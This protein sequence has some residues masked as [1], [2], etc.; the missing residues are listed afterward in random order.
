MPHKFN[1]PRRHRI[2]RAKYRVTNWPEYDRGLVER[3]DVR[4]WIADDAL[5]AWVPPRRCRRGRQARYSDLAIETVLLLAAAFDLPLRQAEGFVRSVFALMDLA[6][7]VPDHTTLARRRRTVSIDMHASGRKAPVDLV[8][9]STGLKFYG[10]G[11]WARKKHGERRRDWRKLHVSVDA[12]TGEILS[13]VL[14]NSDTS[15][16]AMAGPLVENAGGRIRSVIAD[17]A[18]DGAPTMDAIRNARPP[19]SPPK[20]IIPPPRTAISPPGKPHGG[21]E[22]ECHAA[23]IAAHGRIAWQ[24]RNGYGK[25]SHA[26][27]AISR[28]KHRGGATLR[29][30]TFGAQFQEITFRIAVANK[31]IRH[32][33]PITV[34]VT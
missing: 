28:I 13:H 16:A 29:S 27:T 21:S 32:A 17:G 24:K 18:Y 12:G 1:E 22:R 8:L 26:E 5:A 3:G 23:E 31:A 20:I 10:P 15:D 33:K 6:L 30:R 11:E 9:D 25:R 7:P 19:R 2:P 14:T 4:F 34:R